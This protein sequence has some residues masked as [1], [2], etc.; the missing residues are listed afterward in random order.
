MINS[1][2]HTAIYIYTKILLILQNFNG[3]VSTK[4][5]KSDTTVIDILLPDYLDM[6]QDSEWN[7]YKYQVKGMFI[8]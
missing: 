2:N 7:S 6:N 8:I 3:A 4:L 1:W 5:A